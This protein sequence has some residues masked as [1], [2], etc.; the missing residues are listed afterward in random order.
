MKNF[1]FASAILLTACGAKQTPAPVV[2][3]PLQA[4]AGRY[5]ITIGETDPDAV[6]E[7]GF[8]PCELFGG[9]I[10][11]DVTIDGSVPTLHVEGSDGNII[12]SKWDRVE[13]SFGVVLYAR[14]LW[15]FG[16]DDG[17]FSTVTFSLANDGERAFGR[18]MLIISN[19]AWGECVDVADL[20]GTFEPAE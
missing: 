12:E 9:D 4:H 13:E 14:T 15:G 10:T 18:G 7:G 19:D 3:P 5:E 2:P 6:I 11:V 8:I 17:T 16:A 20:T 1:L